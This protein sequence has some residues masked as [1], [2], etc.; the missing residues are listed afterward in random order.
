MGITF[1]GQICIMIHCGSRGLGHQVATDYVDRM[2]KGTVRFAHYE[3][4]PVSATTT[5][6]IPVKDL[7]LACARIDS[8]EGSDYLKAMAAAANYAYCNRSILTFLTRTAFSKILNR[9]PEDM[10]MAL[11][12][13]VSHNMAKF[14]EHLVE[15]SMKRLLV[16][17][18]GSTRAF[19]PHHA[20]I[21]ESYQGIGQP[22]LVGG[23]MGTCSHVLT[24][25]TEGME[26]T[27]GSTCHGAGRAI[28]RSQCKKVLPYEDVLKNLEELGIS[29]VSSN[30]KNISEEAPESYKDVNEVVETCE[31]AKLSKKAFKLKPIGVIKG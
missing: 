14:E 31:L 13:D 29:I 8:T 18:K 5:S 10:D 26:A 12:Y 16:H 3:S 20:K 6:P 4:E 30:P 27:F 19:P 2:Q 23:S 11:I 21:P 7:Q 25:M 15:G 24:G 17:R 22:I 9:S 1:V 28:S